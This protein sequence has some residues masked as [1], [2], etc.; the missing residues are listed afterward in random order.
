[1]ALTIVNLSRD[2]APQGFPSNHIKGSDWYL[3]T[4]CGGKG[5][6]GTCPN[7]YS[8]DYFWWAIKVSPYSVY[9]RHLV[10]QNLSFQLWND[11]GAASG[12]GHS[13]GALS[14]YTLYFSYT[15]PTSKIPANATF[16][17][18]IPAT[19][20]P[21]KIYRFD[22]G[23]ILPQPNNANYDGNIYVT[24]SLPSTN[25]M[26]TFGDGID[27]DYASTNK[28]QNTALMLTTNLDYDSSI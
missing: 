7:P 19:D 11:G 3:I 22:S 14:G 15:K 6:G 9:N 26:T 21:P 4:A 8:G 1:M 25:M 17:M 5:G 2:R 10:L 13:Y 18:N 27:G 23:S 20:V 16:S 12:C 24:V 28:Y